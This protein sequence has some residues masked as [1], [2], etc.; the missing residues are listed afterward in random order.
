M[1]D[2]G[3]HD[4]DLGRLP[5]SVQEAI[6][7]HLRLSEDHT[8]TLL[9]WGRFIQGMTL[10]QVAERLHISRQKASERLKEMAG[11]IRVR[12]E[13]YT[14]QQHGNYTVALVD[15]ELPM[16]EDLKDELYDSLDSRL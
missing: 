11:L 15:P 6:C 10:E 3:E 13:E 12:Y 2:L 16:P 14:S 4:L 7:D 5:E 8:D 1:G 9:F